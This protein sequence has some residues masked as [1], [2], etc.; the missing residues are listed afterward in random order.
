MNRRIVNTILAI[1]MAFGLLALY[2]A[3]PA[4]AVNYYPNCSAV[5]CANNNA[6]SICT[7]PNG[8]AGSCP[9]YSGYSCIDGWICCDDCDA[10]C[11]GCNTCNP[12]S[13]PGCPAN[14]SSTYTTCGSTSISCTSYYNVGICGSCGT[15]SGTCYLV[16]NVVT[17]NGNGGTCT[18]TSRTVC[19]NGTSAAPSCSRTG[20]NLTGFT[21]TSLEIGGGGTVNTSTGAVT[22]VTGD[23]TITANWVINNVAPSA[24]TLLQTESATNPTRVADTTPEFSA[25][26]NDS[27]P[28][29][30]TAVYYQIQVNTSSAFNGTSM[31]DSGKTSMTSTTAGARSPQISYAGTGL[32]LNGS[33]YY[34]RIK[35]WD[36][37][38]AEGAWSTETASFTM[39]RP[40]SAPTSPQAELASNPTGVTDTRPEF[41]AVFEDPDSG[42]TGTYYEIEV[43]TN[44]SFT[45]TV[46]WD[47]GQVSM[48]STAIG[49]YSPSIEYG[50]ASVL[51]LDGTTYYWRIRFTDNNGTTGSWSATAQFTMNTPP[52]APSDPRTEGLVNPINI[53]DLTPEFTAVFQDAN[54]GDTGVY[55]EINVNTNSSFTGT[56]MWNS[57]QQSMT[58]TA[59]G[60][61]SPQISYAGTALSYNG[62]TYYWRI[63]FTDNYGTTGSWSATANFTMNNKPSAPTVLQTEGLTNPQNVSDMTP[64]FS[65]LFQDSNT[66]QTGAYYQIQ[67]NTASDFTGTSMWDSTKTSMTS[68][69]IGARSPQISYA[70]TGLTQSGNLYYWRI[71]FWDNLDAEG[72]WSSVAN[73]RVQRAPSA[74]TALQTDGMNNPGYVLT[75]TPSLSAIYN[76]LNGHSATAYEIEVNTNSSFTG[77][78]MWD[79]GKT[80][81]SVTEGARSPEYVYSG[82]ALQS[83]NTTYYWRIRFWD[84]DDLQGDWS[85]TN[86][87]VSRLN[88][89]F[90]EGLLLKGLRIN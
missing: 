80:S 14:Y 34:W 24:P 1:F 47:S 65:A 67:V 85:A 61:T 57:G 27:T 36:V 44:S 53:V 78:V 3:T 58:A 2:F 9:C 30:D 66:G 71:K 56:V 43:N 75:L 59:I 17:Y 74:P 10:N 16:N 7:G 6:L 15:V 39:N 72:D 12:Y 76:D 90:L 82:T 38:N 41:R 52:S 26:Y 89:Q 37:N 87:F 32:S 18:P 77:T 64:E 86:T 8:C 5:G 69:A 40:P 68:T 51:A 11:G 25:Q 31:W 48:T 23:Q 29:N 13:N 49:A 42:D 88:R 70:G 63:R 22:N 79:T 62:T 20:Y 55:Y 83:D 33:T 46:M 73:F 84:A 54:V 60:A 4:N 35:F 45:G 81:T 50:A 21:R 19:Y 28:A